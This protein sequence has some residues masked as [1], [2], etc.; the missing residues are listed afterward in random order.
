LTVR[1]DALFSASSMSEHQMF[2]WEKMSNAWRASMSDR[3]LE[4][5]A[6]LMRKG[7]V[8]ALSTRAIAAA[9]GTQ[10]PM[11][12]RRFGD[13]EALLEAVA[14]HIVQEH[15]ANM[16]KLIEDIDDP[17]EHL[18]DLWDLYV[19]FAFAQPDC[20]TL[21]YGRTGPEDAISAAAETMRAMV[22]TAVTRVADHGRLVMT[23]ERATAVFRSSGV[24]FVLTQA[25]IPA[26]ERDPG[27]SA[28]VRETAIASIAV[29]SN[30][31]STRSTLTARA[32]AMRRAI[33][34]E[35]IPLTPA[36]HEVMTEW[37]DRISNRP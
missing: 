34:G 10:P 6:E 30:A 3:L 26:A 29:T 28:I 21:I 20:L 36:E 15:I 9:A 7:G 24:G 35:D 16:S 27:L 19:G 23:V 4:A 14:L 8:E 32:A 12:Y 37:L 11:L 1:L 17:I 31:S 33:E 13:K 5:A 2:K 18:R 25:K 22:Q